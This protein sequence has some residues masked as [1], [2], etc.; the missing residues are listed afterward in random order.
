M[1]LRITGYVRITGHFDEITISRTF[2]AKNLVFIFFAKI[3]ILRP[4]VIYD[5]IIT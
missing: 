3:A 4:D 1:D 5:V 2:K